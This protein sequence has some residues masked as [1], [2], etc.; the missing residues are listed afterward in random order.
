M[1]KD[2]GTNTRKADLHVQIN[3]GTHQRL[4]K[5]AFDSETPMCEIVEYALT[6]FWNEIKDA[7]KA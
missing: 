6:R 2:D 4:R 1:N 3:K 5:L 7:I